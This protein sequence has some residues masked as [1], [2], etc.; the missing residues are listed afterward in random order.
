MGVIFVLSAQPTLPNPPGLN[1]ELLSIAGH[2]GMYAV[3]AI[4]VWWALAAFGLTAR[5]RIA[6]AFLVAMLYGVS[7][8]WHQSFVPGRHPD[9][10]DLLVDAAGAATGLAIVVRV[11]RRW[12][13]LFPP[14]RS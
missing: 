5:Q 11:A 7:D 3:L 2:F 13:R 6:I 4:L 14:S 10:F 12:P 1:R 8:E 9:P